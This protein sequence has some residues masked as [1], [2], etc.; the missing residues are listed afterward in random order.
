MEDLRHRSHQVHKIQVVSLARPNTPRE[1]V[2]PTSY[3]GRPTDINQYLLTYHPV[4]GSAEEISQ[5][6]P[7]KDF[8]FS[9]VKL[10]NSYQPTDKRTR[11]LLT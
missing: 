1:V 8:N 11:E 4:L 3:A 6:T 9:E 5:Q 2:G 10:P 7:L